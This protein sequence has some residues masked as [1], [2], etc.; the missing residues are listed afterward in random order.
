MKS[1]SKNNFRKPIIISALFYLGIGAS[2]WFLFSLYQ[3]PSASLFTITY[4]TVAT[5]LLTGIAAITFLSRNK[6]HTVVYLEKKQSATENTQHQNA[7]SSKIN[8]HAIHSMVESRKANAQQVLSELCTQLHA[9]QAAVYSKTGQSI[10]LEYGYALSSDNKSMYEVGEGL[11]GRVAAE[12]K[13]LYIDKLPENYTTVFS[14]LGAA[15]PSFLTIAPIKQGTITTGVIEIATF[16]PLTYETLVDLE[17]VGE[18][19]AILI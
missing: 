19:L 8:K 16:V 2:A 14:G 1:T 6:T 5:T 3:N 11:I 18:Q 7:T 9:G 13:T 17:Q 15:S 12:G 10:K 4:L